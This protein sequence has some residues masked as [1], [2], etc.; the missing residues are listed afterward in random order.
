[1]LS[2]TKNFDLIEQLYNMNF[3]C[4]PEKKGIYSVKKYKEM[5]IEFSMDTTAIKEYS[6]KSM[7]YNIDLL[8]NKFNIWHKNITLYPNEYLYQR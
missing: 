8:K 4:I 5:K 3:S 1:M 6:N 7:I 2:K